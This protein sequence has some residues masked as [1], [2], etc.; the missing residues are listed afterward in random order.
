MNYSLSIER[1]NQPEANCRSSLLSG[2]V[3]IFFRLLARSAHLGKLLV[4]IIKQTAFGCIKN[5]LKF[6]YKTVVCV[7][8]NQNFHS[9]TNT[10]KHTR[11]HSHSN[12]PANNRIILMIL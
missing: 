5:I 6:L 10:C 1:R 4:I 9:L 12:K 2:N 11:K 3:G 7:C 8:S